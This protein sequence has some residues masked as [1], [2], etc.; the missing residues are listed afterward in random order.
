MA[1]AK[2]LSGGA[3]NHQMADTA[4]SVSS[5]QQKTDVFVFDV[6]GNDF[7]WIALKD[8]TNRIETSRSDFLFCLVEVSDRLLIIRFLRDSQYMQI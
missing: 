8:L 7:F 5:H 2:H 4:V 1:A 3:A 6:A